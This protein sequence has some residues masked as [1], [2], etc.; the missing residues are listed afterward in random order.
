M[1]R[2]ELGLLITTIL[3]ISGV[4]FLVYYE[5]ANEIELYKDVIK[6]I[7]PPGVTNLGPIVA[8]VLVTAFVLEIVLW[9]SK[10]GKPYNWS[11]CEYE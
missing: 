2:I 3:I 9:L 4:G 1:N 11:D 7:G 10:K 5:M 8:I 6:E